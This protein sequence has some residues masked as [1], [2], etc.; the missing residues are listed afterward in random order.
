MPPQDAWALL[1]QALREF[2]LMELAGVVEKTPPGM[3]VEKVI[4]WC[5]QNLVS[6]LTH[7]SMAQSYE[8]WVTAQ[9]D[10]CGDL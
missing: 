4:D 6:N 5:H 1:G 8:P 7:F 10:W 2:R 3:P 9:G